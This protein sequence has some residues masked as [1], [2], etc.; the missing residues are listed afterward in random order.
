MH[1]PPVALRTVGGGVQRSSS[2][3]KFYGQKF[4]SPAAVNC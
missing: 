2:L 4:D 1:L 3:V